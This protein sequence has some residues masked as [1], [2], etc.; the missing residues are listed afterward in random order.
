MNVLPRAALPII[1][2]LTKMESI[3]MTN[4]QRSTYP[5]SSGGAN[6]A[7]ASKDDLAS[8]GAAAYREVKASIES[9]IA[10]AGEKGQ[11]ALNYAG[12]KG[13]EAIDN[14][15]EVGDT[16][17]VAIERSVTKRP[18]TTLALAVGLGFLF[19]AIWR[20]R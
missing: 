7:D 12:Q 11:Q 2:A 18:Y 17:T 4:A 13:L 9:V 15:R 14:V 16:L 19:G 1:F 6:A 20:R 5:S 8:K 3:K 10:D